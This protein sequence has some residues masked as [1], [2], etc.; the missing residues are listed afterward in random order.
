MLIVRPL[1]FLAEAAFYLIDRLLIDFLLVHGSGFVAGSL[2]HLLRRLQ[3]GRT[4]TYAAL[5]LFG[6]IVVLALTLWIAGG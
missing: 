1:N 6:C 3:D 5:F 2:G 4:P